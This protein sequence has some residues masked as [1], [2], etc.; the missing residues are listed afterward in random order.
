MYWTHPLAMTSMMLPCNWSIVRISF[1]CI[2]NTHTHKKSTHYIFH[3]YIGKLALNVR[4]RFVYPSIAKLSRNTISKFSTSARVWVS[5]LSAN[6]RL[7]SCLRRIWYIFR[8][9]ALLHKLSLLYL[10][11]DF[12]LIAWNVAAV[13]RTLLLNVLL[14]CFRDDRQCWNSLLN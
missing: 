10:V 14:N 3:K 8:W 5:L 2:C 4:C 11:T 7:N 12:P 9:F 1:V 6:I 13:L